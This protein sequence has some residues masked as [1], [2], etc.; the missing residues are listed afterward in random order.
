MPQLPDHNDFNNSIIIEVNN[1]L[2][3]IITFQTDATSQ[4]TLCRSSR[5]SQ[6]MK[7]LF[8]DFLTGYF[9]NFLQ[10]AVVLQYFANMYM[11][12]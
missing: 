7:K 8:F 3:S 9:S 12:K 2:A 4:S 5:V 1:Y 10:Q 6:L 11:S